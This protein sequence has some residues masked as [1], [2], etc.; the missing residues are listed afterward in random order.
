MYRYFLYHPDLKQPVKLKHEPV[1]WDSLKKMFH[2][3]RKHHGMFFDY[4]NKI[5]FVKDG[6]DIIHNLS[7]R[8]GPKCEII[9]TIEIK[10]TKTSKWD[11]DYTG[12][13]NLMTLSIN[14]IFAECNVDQTGFMKKFRNGMDTRVSLQSLTDIYGGAIPAFTPEYETVTMHSK[15]IELEDNFKRDE[16]GTDVIE[17]PP[18]LFSGILTTELAVEAEEFGDVNTQT[19]FFP[20]TPG[21]LPED[22]GAYL[23][24]IE[25]TA[26]GTVQFD[27]KFRA[28]FFFRA[29]G[30][31]EETSI[32]VDLFIK[33]KKKIDGTVT[34]YNLV[35]IPNTILP[36]A[37]PQ[38]Y[39]SGF[40]DIV[41]TPS[42][43][44][45]K[46][47]E[48]YYYWNLGYS[49]S[50]ISRIRRM[51][52]DLN[53]D[54]YVYIKLISSFQE[55]PCRM[56]MAHEAF[57]RVC[58]ATTGVNDPF[59]S[60]YFGRTD[61]S[62]VTYAGDGA[63]SLRG[64]TNG[65]QL[66]GFPVFSQISPFQLGRPIHASFRELLDTFSAIDGIGVG[67]RVINNREYVVVEPVDYFY[68]AVEIMKLNYVS[69]E[70]PDEGIAKDVDQEHYY[71]EL[72]IGYKK[73]TSTDKQINSL[74]EFNTIHRYSLPFDQV[75][76]KLSLVSPYIASGYQIEQTRRDFYNITKTKDNENDNE[77]FVVQLRRDGG[78]FATAKDEDFDSIEKVISPESI[79]NANLSV[80]RC[81]ARNG[82]LIRAALDKYKEE[83]IRL[84]QAEGNYGM[85]S[86]RTDEAT[87]I[88]E[89]AYVQV[90]T[91]AKPLWLPELYRFKAALTIDQV[92]AMTSNPYGYVSFSE[93]ATNHKKCFILDAERDA[94]TRLTT[95]L[96][97]KANL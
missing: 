60:T 38:Q 93:T 17:S 7:D 42:F 76:R 94:K 51:T 66:R 6:R 18:G 68:Q 37:D 24:K 88:D 28:K 64:I 29:T 82:R 27:I 8:Y 91:L 56:I 1:G 13:L 32:S 3:D 11:H 61:S 2:R 20:D 50:A 57:A 5:K 14:K 59:R 70:N 23:I 31:V 62:P 21:T 87:P 25:E 97:L 36:P 95:F 22:I 84:N 4:T 34:E 96:G 74:D 41:H 45:A 12:K 47:D 40:L 46:D 75:R 67:I 49:S 33:H 78:V 80:K 53:A 69:G 26:V 85:V 10:N 83:Y 30:L 15:I 35:V 48:I 16:D 90:K 55:T 63:G 79:Y 73:W 89:G 81:M 71:N 86:K 72:E 77:N 9:L 58:Q 43:T 52:F 54:N 19:D 92:S 65:F 39:D 44:V